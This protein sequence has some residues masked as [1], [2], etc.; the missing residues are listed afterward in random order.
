MYSTPPSMS[1]S[2]PTP[3]LL[4]SI[5]KDS[6]PSEAQSLTFPR[7]MANAIIRVWFDRQPKPGP[8]AGIFTGEFILHNFF[9]LERIYSPYRAWN[10]A[11]GGS[12]IEAHIY[13]PPEVLEQPD[14]LAPDQLHHGYLSGFP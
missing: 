6:F 8:E 9:W 3:P 4:P 11:S 14:A 12:V 2:Q 10:K 13:G 7:G 5:I 1:S